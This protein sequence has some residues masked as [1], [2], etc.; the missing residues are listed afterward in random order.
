MA[1][2]AGSRE[3]W[4]RYD[5]TLSRYDGELGGWY[6]NTNNFTEDP[7][8]ISVFHFES[9]ALLEDSIG[10][11][12]VDTIVNLVESN[13]NHV[14]G[15]GSVRLVADSPAG[16]PSPPASISR[17]NANLSINTPGK[18]GEVFTECTFSCWIK[19]DWPVRATD[20]ISTD[21]LTTL[22]FPVA[23]IQIR[24]SYAAHSQYD[25][26]Y[27][28]RSNWVDWVLELLDPNVWYH[29]LFTMEKHPVN[30]THERILRVFDSSNQ[31]YIVDNALEFAGPIANGGVLGYVCDVE[32]AIEPNV[33]HA[34]M[35]ELV[36]WDRV[37]TR[38]ETT[39]VALGN[40]GV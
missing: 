13:A 39:A 25:G 2:S 9:A 30:N 3:S 8:V 37:L 22:L 36:I 16:G 15:S 35:D 14:E 20:G 6:F 17:S 31:T 5:L 11:N 23:I 19:L 18:T 40:F 7:N 4:Q 1:D 21:V 38:E 32:S 24:S 26:T 29:F 12:D 34:W 10:T 28:F 27:S 33:H